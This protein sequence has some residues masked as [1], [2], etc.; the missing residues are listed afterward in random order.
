MSSVRTLQ[1]SLALVWTLIRA[2]LILPM[3]IAPQLP[4]VW[5][6]LGH[7][8]RLAASADARSSRPGARL[9]RAMESMGPVAMK[10]GQLLS[11]RGDIFGATFAQDLA[12][13]KDRLPP[14]PRTIAE[15][16]ISK[17][18]GQPWSS[19]F[20]SIEPAIAGASLA[21][22]H[23]AMGLDGRRL[24][25][26]VLRPGIET[27]VVD[28]QR[29]LRGLAHIIEWL[30]PASR[31]LRPIAL[32]E[33]V[34][35]ALALELDLRM[36]AAAGSE[37][38]AMGEV[39]GFLRVPNVWWDGVARRVLTLDWAE[40]MALTDP[41]ALTQPGVDR[42]EVANNLVRAF[43][44]QALDHG[45]FHADLHEGNL[46]LAPPSRLTAVDFGITG[47]L[48]QRERRYLA[49]ILY[50]FLTRD[51]TRIAHWHFEAGYVPPD[52]NRARF[53]LALRA[54]GE[55]IFG[56]PAKAVSM[57]HVMTQLFEITAR[58]NMALRPELVLLQKT[59]LTVEGVARTLDPD[60]DLWAAADPIVR[61]WITR[62]LSPLARA[63]A[64]VGEAQG[65]FH[66]LR[67]R[68]E[69][70]Q[71]PPDLT[72]VRL[73]WLATGALLGA[74]AVG[75]AGLISGR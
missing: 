61:R 14:F 69:P 32:A 35:Q 66:S 15:A 71:A 44:S 17:G 53:A 40:G 37:F 49:E 16:E 21:Q 4:A 3:E 5:R 25:I 45:F 75:L 36:E 73:T 60:H 55:P 1:R 24:A 56:R 12:R 6:G 26:K 67:Q 13:L 46:F 8:L 42:K 72:P 28:D 50:G 22:V 63:E 70:A 52:Q 18:L 43:L 30:L 19:M 23:P 54:V 20:R 39:S 11:T 2:D 34:N 33:T 29:L 10:L 31:R 47:R 74:L 51:Y 9:A 41:A 62:E 59:M 38:A 65:L 57:A 7:L 68:L 27:Q 48:G 64:L 58:F